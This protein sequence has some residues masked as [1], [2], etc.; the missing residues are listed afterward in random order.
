M[1]SYFKQQD[2]DTTIVGVYVDDL[3][4]TASKAILVSVFFDKMGILSIKDLGPVSKFLGI[5]VAIN[6]GIHLLDKEI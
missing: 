5:R 3:L 1:C 2:S 4:V 6:E